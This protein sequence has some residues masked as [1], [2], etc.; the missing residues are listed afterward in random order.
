VLM[1]IIYLYCKHHSLTGHVPPPHSNYP[2][3]HIYNSWFSLGYV[4]MLCDIGLEQSVGLMV[5]VLPKQLLLTY[6]T[7]SRGQ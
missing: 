6:R 1:G 5:T 2:H 4:T 7:A 3:H